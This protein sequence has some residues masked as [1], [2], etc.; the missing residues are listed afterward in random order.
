MNSGLITPET[1]LIFYTSEVIY[2]L[3]KELHIRGK[4]RSIFKFVIR[5]NALLVNKPS[6]KLRSVSYKE[7]LQEVK[8]Y[9]TTALLVMTTYL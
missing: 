8:V 9:A 5:V 3:T 1:S 4:I 6:F 2:D 7:T